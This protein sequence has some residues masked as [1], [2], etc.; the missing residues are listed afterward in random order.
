MDDDFLSN[1]FWIFTSGPTEV[2]QWR[3][4]MLQELDETITRTSEAEAI[5]HAAIPDDMR[6]VNAEINILALK[7][8]LVR[9]QHSDHELP[10]DIACKFRL[11]GKMPSS[12][13]FTQ[14]QT[15]HN[16][17]NTIEDMMMSAESSQAHVAQHQRL[18]RDAEREVWEKA[19]EEASSNIGWLH[20][21]SPTKT[22]LR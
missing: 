5:L 4:V 21:P 13:A 2:R 8:L 6:V 20:G 14:G 22:W 12:G 7:E 3:Q 17:T 1:I 19:L 16:A 15:S 10:R 9:V 18:D 11:L